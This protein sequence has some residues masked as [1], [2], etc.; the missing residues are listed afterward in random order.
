[1]YA[2]DYQRPGT[3]DAAKSAGAGAG[4]RYL[5]GGQSLVQ[6][7]RLRLSQSDR[8]VDL[9]DA[10]RFENEGTLPFDVDRY[11]TRVVYDFLT[12]AGIAAEWSRDN[13]EENAPFGAFD[14]DRYGL[15]LRY[16]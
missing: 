7:M 12:H 14:A 13:Y 9:F 5:A 15:F 3:K 4:V 10:S 11:R 6:A 1:M 8:L 2:F 16:H